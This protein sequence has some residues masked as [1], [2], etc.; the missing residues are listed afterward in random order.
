MLREI[1]PEN[2]IITTRFIPC[3]GKDSKL[4]K[5]ESKFKKELKFET[6]EVGFTRACT[7]KL[8]VGL[9]I[10]YT[11]NWA[12]N[13]EKRGIIKIIFLVFLK[14]ARIKKFIFWNI[15]WSIQWSLTC[16]LRYL[17][18]FLG[19]KAMQK[20]FKTSCPTSSY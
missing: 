6:K 1:S 19:K 10:S 4:F 8:F 5:S 7:T 2:G 15:S 18:C 9:W 3:R 13:E 20:T 17:H 14:N 11:N 16:S 12:V